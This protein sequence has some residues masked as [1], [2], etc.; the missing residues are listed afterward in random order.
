MREIYSRYRLPLIVTKNALGAYDIVTEDGK[1]HDD[2]R[3][4]YLRHHI[5]QIQEAISDVV[6]MMEYC[7]WSAIDLVLTCESVKKRNG[8]IYVDRDEFDLKSLN[9]YKKDSFYWYQ[10]VSTTNEERLQ[11]SFILLLSPKIAV[12]FDIS[13][14]NF[15]IK[16]REIG[17]LL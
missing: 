16:A 11:R 17:L 10:K 7:P 15:F 6:E 8:F 9:Q 3:I 12:F 2:Y 1:I 14:K 13:R 5:E 4:A